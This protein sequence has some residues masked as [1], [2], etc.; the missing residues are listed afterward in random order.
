M[1]WMAGLH[2]L[3]HDWLKA[4]LLALVSYIVLGTIALRRGPTPAIRALA[5]ASALVT[6]GYMVAVATTRNPL[7]F[8]G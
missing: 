1:M 3:D 6:L 8:I 2:P 7:P 5:F 4:K